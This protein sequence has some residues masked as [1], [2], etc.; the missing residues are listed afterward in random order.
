M[1]SNLF[2]AILKIA[3]KNQKKWKETKQL[4]CQ[5]AREK[6]SGRFPQ[7]IFSFSKKKKKL[8]AWRNNHFSYINIICYEER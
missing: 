2:K 8:G 4:E 5:S 6:N 1:F 3:V 7:I